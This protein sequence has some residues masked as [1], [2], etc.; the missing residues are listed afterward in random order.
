ML[1]FEDLSRQR[2]RNEEDRLWGIAGVYLSLDIRWWCWRTRACYRGKWLC[3]YLSALCA[4]FGVSNPCSRHPFSSAGNVP[5]VRA[6]RI[7]RVHRDSLHL[8][9]VQL[10]LNSRRRGARKP[11]SVWDTRIRKVAGCTRL[12]ASGN[13]YRG[14]WDSHQTLLRCTGYCGAGPVSA[15]YARRAARENGPG[16]VK[17]KFCTSIVIIFRKGGYAGHSVQRVPARRVWLMH[18]GRVSVGRLWRHRG[19][20]RESKTRPC[21]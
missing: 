6:H 15:G 11:R 13:V 16:S 5:Q 1:C 20:A 2:S 18:R 19:A 14:R 21:T 3:A 4:L 10:V 17:P 8:H 9:P 12:F 7:C